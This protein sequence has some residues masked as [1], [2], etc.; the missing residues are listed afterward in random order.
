MERLTW[1]TSAGVGTLIKCTGCPFAP[2]C[3]GVCV[4]QD[5]ANT[6]LAEYE[7]TGYSPADFDKLCRE[8][9]DLRMALGLDTYDDLRRMIKDHRVIMLPAPAKE[10]DKKPSCFY[11]YPGG[12]WCPGEAPQDGDEPT[13][14]CKN[15]WYC[16]YGY[17]AEEGNR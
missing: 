3:P 5:R 1:K 14:R 4:D 6:R 17:A 2:R 11:S 15:C 9:S 7:D 10:G 13:E 16:E 12:I 8:M